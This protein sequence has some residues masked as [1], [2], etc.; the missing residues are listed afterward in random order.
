VIAH[1]TVG[2]NLNG[3][4]ISAATP[5][6]CVRD[7]HMLEVD[8]VVSVHST[9]L[10]DVAEYLWGLVVCVN[11]SEGLGESVTVV[12]GTPAVD[13]TFDVAIGGRERECV[14][15]DGMTG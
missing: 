8:G 11:M 1:V 7:S 14:I 3:G 9:D 5:V 6:G 10:G 13:G 15:R 2:F 4:D 12:K